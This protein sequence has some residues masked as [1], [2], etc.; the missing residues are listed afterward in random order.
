MIADAVDLLVQIGIRH[1][2][3]RVVSIDNVCKELKD[4]EVC[5]APIYR[6][7]ESSPAG[8]PTWQALGELQSKLIG[9][10]L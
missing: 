4:G 2:V 5:F 6:Y 1:E 3:R 8:Q 9:E 10:T 7:V